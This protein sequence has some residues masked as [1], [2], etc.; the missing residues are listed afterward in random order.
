MTI[1]NPNGFKPANQNYPNSADGAKTPDE[2]EVS[3]FR[4][5][6]ARYLA[7]RAVAMD[8]ADPMSDETLD[9]LLREEMRALVGVAI[10]PAVSI[11]DFSIKLGLLLSL[12]ETV[13]VPCEVA[14]LAGSLVSDLRHI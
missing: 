10:A 14:A 4:S 2:G 1:Q 12:M 11:D 8:D 13:A 6:Y 5:A 9:A 7:V 3:S